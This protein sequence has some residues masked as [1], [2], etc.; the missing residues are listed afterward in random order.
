MPWICIAKNKPKI[1]AIG[2]TTPDSIPNKNA[3][4]LDPVSPLIGKDTTAP[5]GIFWMPIPIDYIY[6]SRDDGSEVEIFEILINNHK[7]P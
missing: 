6:G 1:A 3:L 2:S 7:V 5:S 4:P